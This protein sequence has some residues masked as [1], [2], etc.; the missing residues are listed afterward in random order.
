MIY[1]KMRT[2]TNKDMVVYHQAM[3][4]IYNHSQSV[5]QCPRCG[6][7]N[8]QYVTE[9]DS[10]GFGFGKG[11]CG[12]ILFGP[13]GLLCGLCGMGKGTTY[14]YWICKNCGNKFQY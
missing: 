8:I 9:S 11:C 4:N 10:Q 3:S 1:E 13:L 14:T 7:T 6:G 5:M 12:Y 2:L